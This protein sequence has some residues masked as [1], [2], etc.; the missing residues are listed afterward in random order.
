MNDSLFEQIIPAYVVED[1]AIDTLRNWLNL[2]IGEVSRQWEVEK[3]PTGIKSWNVRPEGDRWV[4]EVLPA[5]IAVSPGTVDRP[6]VVG[7]GQYTARFRL[8][9]AIFAVGN[10]AQTVNR[11]VKIYAAA[12]RATMLQQS[13][14]N[15]LSQ[16]IE[17]ESEDFTDGPRKQERSLATAVVSFVID[18]EG[19][20]SRFA[21]PTGDPEDH[22]PGDDWPTVATADLEIV[23][24]PLSQEG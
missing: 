12:V 15:G 13:G 17:W 2:Y 10:D 14:L 7:N 16:G 11:N 9:I 5:V 21:G 24:E 19:V 23:R 8:A 4:E 18:V 20:V 22:S 3:P 1:A 6:R